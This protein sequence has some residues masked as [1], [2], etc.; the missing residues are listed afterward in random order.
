MTH[1]GVELTKILHIS[2]LD[3]GQPEP[4]GRHGDSHK[5]VPAVLA[6]ITSASAIVLVN[7][8]RGACLLLFSVGLNLRQHTAFPSS[9]M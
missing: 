8:Y 2:A 5:V 9:E 4:E 1:F 3:A 7:S 6:N